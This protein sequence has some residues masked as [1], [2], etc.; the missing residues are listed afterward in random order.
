MNAEPDAERRG[1][2]DNDRVDRVGNRIDQ[3]RQQGYDKYE[4]CS[5]AGMKPGEQEARSGVSSWPIS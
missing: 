1:M 3:N 4:R 5:T 2:A